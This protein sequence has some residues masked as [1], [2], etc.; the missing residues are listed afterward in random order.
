MTII[1]TIIITPEEE[2]RSNE[3]SKF[4]QYKKYFKIIIHVDPCI[5]L[6]RT[7]LGHST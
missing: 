1:I 5:D 7:F 2:D 6:D 4:R 3:N